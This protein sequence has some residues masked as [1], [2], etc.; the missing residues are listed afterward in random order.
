MAN[1][2]PLVDPAN[3]VEGVPIGINVTALFEKAIDEGSISSSSCFLVETSKKEDG[4]LDEYL[5]SPSNSIN[6][7][8][9]ADVSSLRIN[10]SDEDPFIGVDYGTDPNS[11]ELYRTKVTIDPK[12]TL[13]PNT[14]YAAILSQEVSLVSVFD[15][16]EGVGNTGSGI[17][18][19]KG[20]FSGLTA[21]TYTITITEGGELN[22]V[23]YIWTRLSDGNISAT[24]NAANRFIE[25][26]RGV[27]LKFEEGDYGLADT[28]TVRVVP[29][30]FQVSIFAWVFSTG[31]GDFE[32]PDDEDT[33]SLIN[34][35]VVGQPVVD[36]GLSVVSID[37]P[38]AATRLPL[39]TDTIVITFNKDIEEATLVGNIK[40]TSQ[41]IYPSGSIQE[42]LFTTSVAGNKLTI[43]LT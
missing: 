22:R 31:S 34:I 10:L 15:A 32:R 19:T 1:L 28:F 13:K 38:E 29:S 30:D 42:K 3:N 12:Q 9:N 24:I 41:P 25:I 33:G 8:V 21:D 6:G 20:V 7:I 40:I 37:P 2:T 4:G 5:A 16:E 14:N 26:D 11:G 18:Q 39:D 17:R 36:G 43:T 35:P 27:Q 23:K